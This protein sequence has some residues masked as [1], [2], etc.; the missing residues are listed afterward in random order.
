MEL[1]L[2]IAFFLQTEIMLI[3][4]KIACHV[5]MFY[6]IEQFFISIFNINELTCEY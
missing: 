4:D 5:P 6:N 1:M 2:N 3:Y